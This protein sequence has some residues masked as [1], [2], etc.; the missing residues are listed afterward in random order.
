LGGVGPFLEYGREELVVHTWAVVR[1]SVN[2]GTNLRMLY[3]WALCSSH[4]G[5][6]HSHN[7]FALTFVTFGERAG[8]SARARRSA[9][10]L[11]NVYMEHKPKELY[12]ALRV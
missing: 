9:M 2:K 8:A 5:A 6:I 11:K 1:R 10:V 4:D 3:P 7:A 12:Y